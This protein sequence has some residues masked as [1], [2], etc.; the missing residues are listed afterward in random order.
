MSVKTF[1]I[2]EPA[3]PSQFRIAAEW[4]PQSHV[5]LASSSENEIDP[6]QFPNGNATVDDVQLAMIQAIHA[7][8][9]VRILV[10]SDGERKRYEKLLAKHGVSKNVTF[11]TIDHCDIWL[12]DTGP[13]W[14]I[15]TA[16]TTGAMHPIFLVI[17][18]IVIFL[19]ICLENLPNSLTTN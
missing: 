15:T 5:Y 9:E 6:G 4:E 8:T 17:G 3:L 13:I 2:S 7:C 16:L 10:N 19:T 14:G 1:P 12:R 18:Q 11:M